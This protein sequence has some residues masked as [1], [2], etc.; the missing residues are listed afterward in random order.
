MSPT[1]KKKYKKELEQYQKTKATLH[2]PYGKKIPV[3]LIKKLA[4]EQAKENAV[5]YAK[6]NGKKVCSR[7]H[8]YSGSGPCPICWP[9]RK[10]KK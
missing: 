8:V 5:K 4:K 3:A 1:L 9:G 6:K 7:G 10:K 2:F